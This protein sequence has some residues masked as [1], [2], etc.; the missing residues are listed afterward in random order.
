D[1]HD[2]WF[3]GFTPKLVGVV[4][5]GY[6]QPRSL[7]SSET[8][9]GASMPIWLDYMRQALKDQPETPPGP[10]PNGLTK[11]DGDFYFSEFPPGQAVAR[12]GLPSP[13]DVPVD[14]GGLDGIADLLNQLTS[15]S[16]REQPPNV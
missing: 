6:D 5:M 8:G 10:I 15:G 13:N 7:G 3:A 16:Q 12:V 9:G 1:S 11:I 4:W 2:A 14:G